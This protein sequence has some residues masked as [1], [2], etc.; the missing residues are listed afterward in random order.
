MKVKSH[1]TILKHNVPVNIEADSLNVAIL[2]PDIT[3][4]SDTFQMFLSDVVKDMTQK[5]GQKCTAVRRILVSKD[6]LEWT[7]EALID[8]LEQAV[9]GHPS[10]RAT[11]VGPLATSAQKRDILAGIET[12]AGHAECVWGD[13]MAVPANG[14]YVAPALYLVEGG[15][16]APFVHEHEVFG[17]VATLVPNDGNADE[18]VA[19][20]AAGGGGLVASL[21]SDDRNWSKDVILGIAPWNGRILWGSR[22]IADQ[23]PGPGTVLPT[24]VHGGPGKAGGGEELGGQRGL[25]F[26]WQRTAIQGDRALLEKIL[27]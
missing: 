25:S 27:Q 23:S 24:L 6:Q 2:G 10:E 8:R 1:P 20:V 18:V 3:P 19:L 22:K 21:Y 16:D 14:F 15:V 13:P 4:E 11:T 7:K 12:L 9:V 5:A 26:Y 17:P